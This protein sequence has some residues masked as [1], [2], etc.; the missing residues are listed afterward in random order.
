MCHGPESKQSSSHQYGG[1]PD[2]GTREARARRELARGGQARHEQGA[3]SAASSSRGYDELG[4]R[5]ASEVPRARR[6]RQIAAGRHQADT[7]CGP[8][9]RRWTLRREQRGV[10]LLGL[11]PRK[12][13][14]R[15]PLSKVEAA[16][17]LRATRV[18]RHTMGKVQRLA[19]HGVVPTNGPV[20]TSPTPGAPVV[21][22]PVTQ[23][24]I[25]VTPVSPAPIV[26]PTPPATPPA[27]GGANGAP[28]ASVVMNG[29]AH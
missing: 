13:A 9:L 4:E 14:Q 7:R 17:K 22:P 26:S 21:S 29:A 19:I 23:A 11:K 27:D 5:R 18:A 15:T 6:S 24:P 25:V 10:R 20:P 1:E 16:E 12:V 2:L 3:A 28:T 8:E